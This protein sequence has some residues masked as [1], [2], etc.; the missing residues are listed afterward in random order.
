MLTAKLSVETLK[1]VLDEHYSL[2]LVHDVEE[3]KSLFPEFESALDFLARDGYSFETDTNLCP[4]CT[5]KV[6]ES[7]QNEPCRCLLH[8]LLVEYQERIWSSCLTVQHHIE[9]VAFEM[10]SFN[11]IEDVRKYREGVIRRGEEYTFDNSFYNLIAIETERR[12]NEF[13]RDTFWRDEETIA[14]LDCSLRYGFFNDFFDYVSN[15]SGF[16]LGNSEEIFD[17]IRSYC[18]SRMRTLKEDGEWF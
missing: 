8:N 16:S 10:A 11:V 6:A 17:E 2:M 4:V 7:E 13:D 9:D 5:E 1:K 15:L 3:I 18:L 14:V 12:F